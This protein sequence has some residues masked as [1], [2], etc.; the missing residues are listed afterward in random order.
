LS[1]EG[2]R[3]LLEKPGAYYQQIL[4]SLLEAHQVFLPKAGEDDAE[5]VRHLARQSLGL[6]VP[7]RA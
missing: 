7:E 4:L 5:E 1:R 3:G 2:K 6:D